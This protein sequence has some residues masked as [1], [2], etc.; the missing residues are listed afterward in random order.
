MSQ[1]ILTPRLFLDSVVKPNAD[2]LSKRNNDVRLAVNAMLTLDAFFGILYADLRARNEPAVAG[3]QRD[4]QYRDDL[5]SHSRDYQILRDAAFS[6]KHGELT[7]TKPRL[8]ENV[9]Q[10]QAFTP[11]AG[12]FMLGYDQV[13]EPSDPSSLFVAC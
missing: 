7:G 3:F 13:G 9:R 1:T 4:H 8:V 5:A 11:G 6:I 2:E 10:I 12:V